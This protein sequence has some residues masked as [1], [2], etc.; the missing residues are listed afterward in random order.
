MASMLFKQ[1]LGA[2]KAVIFL[3]GFLC[4]YGSSIATADTLPEGEVVS[5][6]DNPSSGNLFAAYTRALYR[7]DTE[8]QE[9]VSISIP[10][11]VE[12]ITAVVA[13]G[14]GAIYL[15]APGTGI[16]HSEDGGKSWDLRNEGLSSKEVSGL[17][18]HAKQPGTLYA[19]IPEVGIFR[20]EDA[21]KEWLLMDGGPD[22]MTDIMIHSDMPD[23]MQTGWIFAA[24][25]AGV[26]RSMDCFCLWREAG[27]LTGEIAG[28]TF[29]PKQ[30][31]HIYAATK[32]GI[33]RSQNGGE[34]WEP[35]GSTKT[36]L[37]ALL[38]TASGGLYA[39]TRNGELFRGR[40]QAKTWERLDVF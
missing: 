7:L 38:F 15:A 19:L 21:G 32:E 16:L 6:S 20:S 31:S 5:L 11:S 33:F 29:D 9:W 28:L 2:H 35:I 39:G 26:S 17:I 10:D 37:T 23:S 27:T 1:L 30:P 36:D 12:R 18:R 40:D 4:L 14:T 22:H 24:T 13:E 8:S 25:K 3:M 34:D